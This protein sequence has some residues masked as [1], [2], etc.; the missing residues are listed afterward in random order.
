MDRE[1]LEFVEAASS[2][3]FHALD[4]SGAR[5]LLLLVVAI[6]GAFL[7]AGP[8][9]P[10]LCSASASERQSAEE[11]ANRL[12]AEGFCARAP[13]RRLSVRQRFEV[14][15][16]SLDLLPNGVP[17]ALRAMGNPRTAA[18]L[19]QDAKLGSGAPLRC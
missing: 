2:R 8:A 1:R 15:P 17:R 13:L 5:R 11:E 7:A 6:C 3:W 12:D 16:F 9:V 4:G 18:L 14:L 10:I 19:D